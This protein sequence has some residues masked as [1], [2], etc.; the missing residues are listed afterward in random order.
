MITLWWA[1]IL[2]ESMIVFRCVQNGI[3]RTYPFFVSY[4]SCVLFSSVSGY[5]VY[6]VHRSLYQS[7]YWALEF[8]CV[9]AG[10]CLV[11]EILEKA[12][13]SYEGPRTL[14]RNGGLGIFALIVAF[15]TFQWRFGHH[16]SALRTSVEVERNLRSAEIALIAGILL[17][18]FYYAIPIGR[19]LKGIALGY[20]LYVAID[21]IDQAVMSHMGSRFQA[22]FSAVRS[23]SYFVS[24]LIW[25]VALWS[26]CPNPAPGSSGDAGLDYDVLAMKT[27]KALESMRGNLGKAARP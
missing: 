26:Y 22:I 19:N 8:V 15:T 14:A 5:A 10:Y 21:V 17:L 25:I 2:L 20:G 3:V 9:F 27:R 16:S 23:Y 4:V 11:L 7:W 24:L 13:A 18:V 6:S 1:G 12:L